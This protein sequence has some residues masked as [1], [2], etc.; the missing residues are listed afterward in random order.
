MEGL[1]PKELIESG[2][3]DM[4]PHAMKRAIERLEGLPP[5]KP[6]HLAMQTATYEKIAQALNR[7]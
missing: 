2:F 5:K 3:I 7:F 6:Y 1:N 4:L